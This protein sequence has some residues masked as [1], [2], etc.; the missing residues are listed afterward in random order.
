MLPLKAFFHNKGVFLKGEIILFRFQ[1]AQALFQ[2]TTRRI[3]RNTSWSNFIFIKENSPGVGPLMTLPDVYA[4]FKSY[5]FHY[6]FFISEH[7]SANTDFDELKLDLECCAALVMQKFLLDENGES[8]KP[9]VLGF[10]TQGMRGKFRLYQF[11][12][13]FFFFF[14][15]LFSFFFFLF[16]FFFF[17]FSF[18]FFLFSFFFFLF[19]FFFFWMATNTRVQSFLEGK[20][21]CA[22]RVLGKEEFDLKNTE[23]SLLVAR[24][25]LS[26]VNWFKSKKFQVNDDHWMVRK[27][28]EMNFLKSKKGLFSTPSILLNSA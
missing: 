26:F 20:F 15:F 17:L 10:M 28:E 11:A 6:P 19:S 16:S 22:K 13:I 14:F 9:F 23:D 21:C 5:S 7:K 25:M 24:V 2:P 12:G 3:S 4:G 27:T 18:F 8:I 1:P